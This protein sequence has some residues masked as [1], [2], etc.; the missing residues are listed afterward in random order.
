MKNPRLIIYA[1]LTVLLAASAQLTFAQ[2]ETKP[3]QPDPCYDVV[4]QIVVASNAAGEKASLPATLAPVVKKLKT[5]YSFA[6]YRLTTTFLQRTSNTIKYKS[7]INDSNL[8]QA[9]NA[10]VFSEWLL[11]NLRS[12]GSEPGRRT[13]QF[14]SFRFGARVPVLMQPGGEVGKAMPIVNYEP[15]GIDGTRFSV[16]ENEPTVI[17][18]LATAKADELMFLVLTVK[19]SE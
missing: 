1:L 6:D 14:D 8:N 9:T 15:I 4:L 19:A 13:I 5:F 17:G 12:F 7:M 18:S 2:T 16:R 11:M 10:P 3:A